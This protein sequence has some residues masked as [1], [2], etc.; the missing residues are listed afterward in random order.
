M[1]L[2][3]NLLEDPFVCNHSTE[4]QAPSFSGDGGSKLPFEKRQE[5]AALQGKRPASPQAVI[6][7]LIHNAT[8]KIHYSTTAAF[9]ASSASNWGFTR[10]VQI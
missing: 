10:S 2:S 3:L 7:D 8:F 4:L 6:S 5:A 9:G 1:T